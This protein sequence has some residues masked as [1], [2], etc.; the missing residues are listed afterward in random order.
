M[1]PHPAIFF[2]RELFHKHGDYH[3]GFRICADYELITRFF[4]IH[5]I[6]WKFF[7]ITTH[8][9]LIG[10]LSSSG[11]NSYMIVSKEII[12]SLI[13]NKIKF[14]YLKIY[15]RFFWKLIEFLNNK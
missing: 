10:G 5:E 14:S 7:N 9:M 4:L 3:L 2:K 8:S 13:I 11:F 12:K 15:S 1:P 6:S